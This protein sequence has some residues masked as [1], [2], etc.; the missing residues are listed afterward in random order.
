MI[1]KSVAVVSDPDAMKIF[2]KTADGF[3]YPD[4]T[5]ISEDDAKGICYW[6]YGKDWELP[7]E[8]TYAAEANTALASGPAVNS[9]LT[10]VDIV[11]DD[12]SRMETFLGSGATS[13]GD[14]DV[15]DRYE[16]AD[17]KYIYNAEAVLLH[18]KALAAEASQ[19]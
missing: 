6:W 5:S 11:F 3:K 13:T 7:A 19:A 9:Y 17:G 1:H 16:S 12:G 15:T 14:K 4:G 8:S 18:L 2:V 10:L